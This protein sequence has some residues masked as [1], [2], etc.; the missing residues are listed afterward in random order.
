MSPSL[1]LPPSCT[2]EKRLG[3]AGAQAGEK[4][5][6]IGA[7]KKL[8]LVRAA[9]GG[10]WCWRA[11]KSLACTL[12]PPTPSGSFVSQKFSLPCD[13][14]VNRDAHPSLTAR[15][16]Q[17]S[18]CSA[19]TGDRAS[20]LGRKELTGGSEGR[21]VGGEMGHG[22]LCQ[23]PRGPADWARRCVCI[24]QPEQWPSTPALSLFPPG[25]SP[26]HLPWRDWSEGPLGWLLSSGCELRQ[27][28]ACQTLMPVK[29]TCALTLLSSSD[30]IWGWPL[31]RGCC[32]SVL[33]TRREPGTFQAPAAMAGAGTRQGRDVGSTMGLQS[34]PG[35]F[36]E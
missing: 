9:A 10:C 5:A 35:L 29:G 14:P 32:C 30:H 27:L 31:A 2:S 20:H 23:F 3:A 25:S 21:E 22:P 18:P 33:K 36:Q 24:A 13:P 28:E 6:Y 7:C 8:C 26:I 16:S 4:C 19:G 1:C 11:L 15:S 12:H 34:S 17:I